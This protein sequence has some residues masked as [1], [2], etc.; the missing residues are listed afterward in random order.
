MSEPA[1]R[2]LFSHRHGKNVENSAGQVMKQPI[3]YRFRQI[4]ELLFVYEAEVIGY[5][6]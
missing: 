5:G 2:G 4:Q 6:T 3:Y 1:V